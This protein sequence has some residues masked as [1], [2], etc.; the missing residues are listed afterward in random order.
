M[1]IAFSTLGCPEW[2]FDQVLAAAEQYGYDGIEFRGLHGEMNLEDVPEFSPAQIAETRT[3]LENAG[4][5]AVCLSS[6]VQVVAS[7]K[8][9][10][11]R[12][13]AIAQAER[14]IDMAKEIGAA[15]VRV[16]CGGVPVDMPRDTAL[17]LAVA[18]LRTLGDFAQARGVTVVAETHDAFTRTE[19][20]GGLV[21]RVSH[22]A[23]AAL[24]DIHH[25]YR[26][27]GESIAHST[28]FL[29]GLVRYTH[30]KD[31]VFDPETEQH[32]YVLLG[33]GDVPLKE[34]L[35]ALK[36]MGYDGFLTLEWEKR[37]IPSLAAPEIAFP[38]YAE[39]MRGWLAE[40]G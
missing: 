40:L 23:V 14:Y 3:R 38:H 32:T 19:D 39:T 25:P 29:D 33:Q 5:A 26:A 36:E 16:F 9:E 35:H 10:V 18:T 17:D 21:R 13:A 4:L 27:A 24:W 34:A 1:K 7:T 15:Y 8:T 11:D 2:S 31:S 20:L 12:H 6:S 22:P 37:W 28:R 30:V